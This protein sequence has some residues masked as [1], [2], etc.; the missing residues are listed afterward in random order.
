MYLLLERKVYKTKNNQK[1]KPMSMNKYRAYALQKGSI[2][3][4]KRG[5]LEEY[6]IQKVALPM[7]IS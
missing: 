6:K 2:K 1:C 4:N 3:L 7:I 5:K